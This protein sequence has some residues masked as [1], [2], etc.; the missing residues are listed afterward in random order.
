MTAPAKKHRRGADAA[1]EAILRAAE[2]VFAE[3]GFREARVE[4]IG[5]ICGYSNSLIVHHYF[6]SKKELYEA[7]MRWLKEEKIERLRRIMT[8]A[9]FYDDAP[10]KAD[11]VQRFIEESIRVS[12]NQ[13]I[14]H[15]KFLRIM[16]WEAAAG[17]E[18]L[19][20]LPLKPEERQ[21]CED[22]RS[23]IRRAQVEGIIWPELD[24]TLLMA[25]VGGLSFHYL[26][27][28][29]RYLVLFADASLASPE[30][31]AEAREK[32]VALTLRSILVHPK[33]TLPHA[34]GL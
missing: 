12:F 13:F 21:W 26:L 23:F 8:P 5:R 30:A 1:R 29:P 32:I 16:A 7:V 27:S 14:E 25:M 11:A 24:P 15:P 4:D 22:V 34:T 19:N 6:K 31:L 18:N 10:L 28:L 33:E 20:K 9:G 17:W 3:K 2:E